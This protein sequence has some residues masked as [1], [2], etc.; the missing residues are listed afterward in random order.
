MYVG[1]FVTD[2][3]GELIRVEVDAVPSPSGVTAVATYVVT[4]FEGE[5]L[6]SQTT[7]GPDLYGVGLPTLAVIEL[8][9][10]VHFLTPNGGA[11]LVHPSGVFDQRHM[12]T[13]LEC[14]GDSVRLNELATS[15]S[16]Q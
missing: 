14:F 2:D 3:C 1:T 16:V 13:V 6:R 11:H 7:L 9:R 10:N 5:S 4:D 12:R 15:A 8:L